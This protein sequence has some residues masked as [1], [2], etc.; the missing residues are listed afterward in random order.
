MAQKALAKDRCSDEHHLMP[1]K[2]AQE[3]QEEVKDLPLH[4]HTDW[5]ADMTKQLL[6]FVSFRA[7]RVWR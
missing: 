5:W 7:H 1:L 4:H 2:A 3:G 6:V